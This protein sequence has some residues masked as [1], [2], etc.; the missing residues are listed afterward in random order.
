MKTSLLLAAGF[1]IAVAGLLSGCVEH[2]VV[3]VP[4]PTPAVPADTT[5]VYQAPPP[6]PAQEVVVAAPGPA[7][8]WVPGYWSWQ[9]RWVW[10]GGRYVVRPHP[11]AVLVPGHWARH[12][13]GYIWVSG[14][15]R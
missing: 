10:V 12:G 6:P 4:T 9:G 8:V 11:H 7:Y 13:H 1:G 2:R 14:Y 3:Y 15:W 5:V